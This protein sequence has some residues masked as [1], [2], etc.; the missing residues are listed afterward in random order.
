MFF[1]AVLLL[2]GGG[3]AGHRNTGYL[4]PDF[5]SKVSWK[6]AVLPFDNQSLEIAASEQ[7]RGMVASNIQ[8]RGYNPIP[9]AEADEKLKGLGITDGGQ[10]P[11]VTP[12]KLGEALGVDALFYGNVEKFIFQ[13]IGF[14]LRRAV[15]VRV[16]LVSVATGET[17]WEDYGEKTT[18]EA[19]LKKKI[20]ER[21]FARG[22][23]DKAAENMLHR[24]L[25]EESQWAV[26]NLVSKLP[27]R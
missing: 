24:P 14:V 12:Q 15:R 9:A 8:W 1:L 21:I 13:N 5:Y 17:L 27:G 10:L 26:V 11:S 19:T 18:I 6:V 7:L 23:A 3:C 4:A 25:W 16:K 2:A 20:A 22:M